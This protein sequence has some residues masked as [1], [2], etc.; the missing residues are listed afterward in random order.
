MS[1]IPWHMRSTR[2]AGRRRTDMGRSRSWMAGA[3]AGALVGC[4]S[5]GMSAAGG[6]GATK[7]LTPKEV[8]AAQVSSALTRAKSCDDLLAKI[9]EDVAA[10]IVLQAELLKL[11][12][13]NNYN[14]GGTVGVGIA[15]PAGGPAFAGAAPQTAAP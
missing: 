12:P 1:I 10:K 14:Y 7:S 6:K 5:G 8:V 13:Q 11:G 4:G 2:A 3:L 15:Q 9:Q